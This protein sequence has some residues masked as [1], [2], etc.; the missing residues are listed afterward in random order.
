MEME[1]QAYL[2]QCFFN[3]MGNKKKKIWE[4]KEETIYATRSS[5]TLSHFSNANFEKF[6]KTA[7]AVCLRIKVAQFKSLGWKT[8]GILQYLEVFYIL[9]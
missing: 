8:T 7:K 3:E 1:L 2:V 4:I 9:F 6:L 5:C